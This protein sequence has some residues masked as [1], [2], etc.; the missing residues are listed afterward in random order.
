MWPTETTGNQI[1]EEGK[2]FGEKVKSL[3][4]K[5]KHAEADYR[6]PRSQKGI[7]KVNKHRVRSVGGILS[8]NSVAAKIE[9]SR[10][11]VT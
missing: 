7:D 10:R 2:E 1:H 3:V 11:E 5:R 8:V 9:T 4:C 6:R